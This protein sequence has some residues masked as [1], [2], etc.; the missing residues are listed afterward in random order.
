M[1]TGRHADSIRMID[2]LCFLLADSW[3]LQNAHRLSAARQVALHNLPMPRSFQALG[4][5]GK[6]SGLLDSVE[7]DQFSQRIE[8]TAYTIANTTSTRTDDIPHI[9]AFE[10]VW[11]LKLTIKEI[12][13]CVGDWERALYNRIRWTSTIQ[14]VRRKLLNP[15]GID[16]RWPDLLMTGC[17]YKV[18]VIIEADLRCQSLLR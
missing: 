16:E 1:L 9:L 15:N 2:V 18:V 6:G 12:T 10:N 8:R 3:N 5:I 4:S 17:Q 14:V 11:R 7:S 13:S